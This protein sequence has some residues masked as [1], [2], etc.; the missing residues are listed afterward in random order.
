MPETRTVYF[1]GSGPGDPELITLRAKKLVEEADIIIYS[2]SL[3]N[4]TILKYS[5]KSAQLYDAAIIDREK[6]YHILHDSAKEGKIAIRFH[7]GDPAL[8]STIREQIDKLEADGIKCKVVPGVTAILGASAD[9]NLELTLPGVT[10]TLIITRAE[11]RTP[12]PQ[13]E[14]IA[15]LAK[16]GATMAFYL[17]VHL[18]QDVVNELLNGGVYTEKTPVAVVY[19]ATWEDEKII[20]GTLGDIARKT[21]EAKIIKTA[22]I[23]VG[24]VIAPAKYEYSKVYDAGFTHGYRKGTVKEKK[25]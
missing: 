4:P 2:G 20:K 10:Q 23:I 1:V 14:S 11:L 12:V 5:K 19:R 15:E 17:S 7:D 3:L 9:M 16:H 6:I 18:I 22:L 8:F 24:D 21:K 13:R 25:E